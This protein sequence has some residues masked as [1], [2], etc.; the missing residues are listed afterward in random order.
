M[1]PSADLCQ[2]SKPQ[3]LL[4]EYQ[5]L[6]LVRVGGV[7]ARDYCVLHCPT[8]SCTSYTLALIILRMDLGMGRWIYMVLK[9][10]SRIGAKM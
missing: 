1:R 4:E 2:V 8:G 6:L 3:K 10:H 9:Q 7:W 5:T